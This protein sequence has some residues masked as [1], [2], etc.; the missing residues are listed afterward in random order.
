MTKGLNDSLTKGTS[1]T[2]YALIDNNRVVA[3]GGQLF[4]QTQI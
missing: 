3:G 4:R 2:Y 1:A